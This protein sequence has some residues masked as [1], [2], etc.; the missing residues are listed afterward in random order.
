M[1]LKERFCFHAQR[2]EGATNYQRDGK[3][4]GRGACEKTVVLT[5]VTTIDVCVEN[6]LLC[7]D[8]LEAV[9]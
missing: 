7:Q 5:L 9:A 6:A 1:A 3:H 8:K 2:S 4:H